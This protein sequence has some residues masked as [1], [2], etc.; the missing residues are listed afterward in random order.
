M[1]NSVSSQ[2]NQKTEKRIDAQWSIFD[3]FEV[4]ECV[5]KHYVKCFR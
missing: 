1:R 2:E 3:N 5:M 4:F